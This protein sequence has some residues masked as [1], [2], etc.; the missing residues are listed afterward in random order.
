[1]S[2][3]LRDDILS[4]IQGRPLI[5]DALTTYEIVQVSGLHTHDIRVAQTQQR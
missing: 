2:S 4:K 1:M 5:F 3:Q